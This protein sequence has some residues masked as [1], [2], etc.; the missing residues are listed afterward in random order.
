MFNAAQIAAYFFLDRFALS[1]L[2][3]NRVFSDTKSLI[4]KLQPEFDSNPRT[5]LFARL[6][7]AYIAEGMPAS[8]LKICLEGTTHHPDHAVGLLLL[9]KCHVLLRQYVSARA[10]LQRL[11]EHTIVAPGAEQLLAQIPELEMQYPPI[12]A[13]PQLHEAEEHNGEDR[14]SD[15]DEHRLSRDEAVLPGTDAHL[16][17]IHAVAERNPEGEGAT[18]KSLLSLPSEAFDYP[19]APAVSLVAEYD[20]ESRGDD[21][22]L[23]LSEEEHF[24][25]TV[26]RSEQESVQT[27]AEDEA[28]GPR[29]MDDLEQLASRLETARMPSLPVTPVDV[30]NID[31]E[32]QKIE[33]V[34]LE[35]RPVTETLA[36]IYMRQG[37]Y[38]EAIEAYRVLR[39]LHRERSYEFTSRIAELKRLLLE[40][41]K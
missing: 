22:R 8:A 17:S 16:P 12:T 11:L 1:W 10:V 27:H 29:S 9:A 6:A 36:T 23:S 39:E 20:V 4:E 35:K 7:D 34:N 18:M 26:T 31:E 32:A 14:E 21:Q 2:T 28:Q 3:M 19:E 41:K 40:Q 33:E 13:I 25:E 30:G 15:E 37:K 5:P 24:D 38:Q